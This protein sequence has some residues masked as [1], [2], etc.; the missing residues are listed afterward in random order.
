MMSAHCLSSPRSAG[1]RLAAAALCAVFLLAAA[2]G[3]TPV[4]KRA[5]STPLSDQSMN[6]AVTAYQNGD[7]RESIRRFN[8]ALQG[9]KQFCA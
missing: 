2:S 6:G 7:C 1:F 3:C 5:A 8:E 4:R 9:L